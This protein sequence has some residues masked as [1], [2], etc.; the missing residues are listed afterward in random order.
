[1][2]STQ[3]SHSVVYMGCRHLCVMHFS[4]PRAASPKAAFPYLGLNLLLL[5]KPLKMWDKIFE[6]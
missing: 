1:M 2:S 5:W 3:V 6:K 4:G